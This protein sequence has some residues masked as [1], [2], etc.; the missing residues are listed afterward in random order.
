LSSLRHDWD[1]GTYDRVSAPQVR[2]GGPVAARLPL[3][4]DE[5]VLD[6][7]CG[8][9]RVTEAVLDRLPGGR[10]IGLDGSARMVEEARSRLGNGGG[11]LA[12]MVGDLRRRLPV[13]PG[14]LDAIVSTATFHW[15][16]DHDALF[17]NLA[18]TLRPGG[19][20]EAQ[21]GGAGN[22]ASVMEALGRVAPGES[23]PYTFATEEEA[24]RGLEAAGFIE[25]ETW[26]A[27]ERTVFPN[28]EELASFLAAVVLWPQLRDRDRTEHAGFVA[29]VVDELPAV[30]LD[31]VRLNM[32]A[33]RG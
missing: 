25:V 28:R 19:R 8:T 31:Y 24:A 6:A 12:F 21:C 20:L 4:G 26:L 16:P 10:V 22:I 33:K 13:A 27:E 7:G 1:A 2:W 9:G 23:Y 30:E 11:R 29:R 5:L 32:R 14:R 17:R 18:E 15:L 3:A